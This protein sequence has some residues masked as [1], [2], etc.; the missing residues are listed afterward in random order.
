MQTTI[1]A[2][3]VNSITLN[4]SFYCLKCQFHSAAP[5]QSGLFLKLIQAPDCL[6]DTGFRQNNVYGKL[7]SLCAYYLR[8]YIFTVHVYTSSNHVK[9]VSATP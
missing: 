7:T 8:H 5:K 3:K 1:T 9:V 2:R 6:A 4:F